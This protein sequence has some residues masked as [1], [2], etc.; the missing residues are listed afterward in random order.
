MRA[1]GVTDDILG[2]GFDIVIEGSPMK[3]PIPALERRIVEEGTQG[4]FGTLDF[5][6]LF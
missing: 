6:L 1:L 5:A 2:E 3:W 4:P